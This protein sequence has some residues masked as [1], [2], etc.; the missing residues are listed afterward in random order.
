[1]SSLDFIESIEKD[2]TQQHITRLESLLATAKNEGAS[3]TAKEILEIIETAKKFNT[4][5]PF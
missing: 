2:L 3:R 1:M 5:I 4:I